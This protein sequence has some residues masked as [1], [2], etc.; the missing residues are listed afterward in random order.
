MTITGHINIWTTS[1]FIMNSRLK[2]A[3][4]YIGEEQRFTTEEELWKMDFAII[5]FQ[6]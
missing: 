2:P 5:F 4:V 6:S 1:E 3:L